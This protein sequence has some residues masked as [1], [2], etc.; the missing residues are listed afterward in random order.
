MNQQRYLRNWLVLPLPDVQATRSND[1]T[2]ALPSSHLNASGA[3]SYTWTPVESLNNAGI[4]NP[5]ATPAATIVYTVIGKGE[6]G[7]FNSDTVSVKVGFNINALY[8]LPNSFTPN[9]DGINDC[10][11]IKYW[12]Q[13]DELDFSI[14]N[15]FGERV[16]HTNN[17]AVCWDGKYKGQPQDPNVFVYIIK[18]KTACGNIDRKGT[19]ILLR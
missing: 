1:I 15:R 12:G 5:I 6:N 10:F 16:F 3:Q 7:C 9:G 2:C 17:P 14:Y 4:A 8:G 13:V 11:G 19:V 18:A